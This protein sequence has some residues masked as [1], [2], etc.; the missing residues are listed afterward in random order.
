MTTHKGESMSASETGRRLDELGI[1]AVYT[2]DKI[3]GS[4]IATITLGD[5]KT[6]LDIIDGLWYVGEADRG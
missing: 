2:E 5:A 4:D 6:L 1:T 3:D